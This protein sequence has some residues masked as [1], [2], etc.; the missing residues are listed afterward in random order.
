MSERVMSVE[1]EGVMM[2]IVNGYAPQVGC[3]MKEK[4]I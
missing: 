4:A 3:E 2:N 1:I